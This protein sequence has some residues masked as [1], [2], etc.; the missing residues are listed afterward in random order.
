ML[1]KLDIHMQ[2]KINLATDLTLFRKINSKCRRQKSI[3]LLEDYIGGHLEDLGFSHEF[4]NNNTKSVTHE[5]NFS[6]LNFIK[7]KKV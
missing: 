4:L 5:K 6:K 2:K 7:V 3:K 1:E